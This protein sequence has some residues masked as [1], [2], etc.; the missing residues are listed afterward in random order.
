MA[1][2][3]NP[4]LSAIVTK[5]KSFIETFDGTKPISVTRLNVLSV[6]PVGELV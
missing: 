4:C 5:I 1:A 2:P 6:G 3:L